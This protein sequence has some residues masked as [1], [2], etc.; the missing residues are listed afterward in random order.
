MPSYAQY[1]DPEL[2]EFFFNEK[3]RWIPRSMVCWIQG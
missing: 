2:I 1:A 3:V